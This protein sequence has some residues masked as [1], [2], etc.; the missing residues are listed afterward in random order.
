[1]ND[2]LDLAK[3]VMRYSFIGWVLALLMMLRLPAPEAILPELFNQPLQKSIPQNEFHFPYK[4]QDIRVRPIMSYE[5]AG[6]VVSHNDPFVWYNFDITHDNL[7]I[8]TRD[9]C[10]IWGSNL[11]TA[12][13]KRVRFYNDDWMCNWSYSSDVRL[14]NDKEI[15]NNHLITANDL[16]RE[17][18]ANL[19]VGDQIRIQGKLVFYSE[20]R[21]GGN[22]HATSMSREDTGNMSPEIIYVDSLTV[23]RSHNWVWALM[24]DVCF[25]VC[26]LTLS[27][28]VTVFL[29]PENR[30]HVPYFLQRIYRSMKRFID[31]YRD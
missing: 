7:S 12:D 2:V 31:I 28:R 29:V 5:I 3:Q 21:W 18:I 22:M 25:W 14:I 10:L 13:Y 9:V 30:K 16:V 27:F 19:R 20:E 24:R 4:N 26:V 11:R 6:L 1:M 15:S 8:N 23:L 17:Q